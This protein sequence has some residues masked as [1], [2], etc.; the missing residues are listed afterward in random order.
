MISN[1]NEAIKATMAKYPQMNKATATY[2]VEEVL[3]YF[4]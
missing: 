1:K 3:G 4:K 2:Y